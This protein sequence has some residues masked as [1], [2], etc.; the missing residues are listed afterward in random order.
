MNHQPPHPPDDQNPD[1]GISKS[2]RDN[3]SSNNISYRETLKKYGLNPELEQQEEDK[4]KSTINAHVTDI[5]VEPHHDFELEA[6]SSEPIELTRPSDEYHTVPKVIS[7]AWERLLAISDNNR[8]TQESQTQPLDKFNLAD[9]PSPPIGHQNSGSWSRLMHTITRET[10]NPALEDSLE[11]SSLLDSTRLQPDNA[12]Q[13]ALAPSS[14]P[15]PKQ[16]QQP[17][18]TALPP[19]K[20]FGKTLD[21]HKEQSAPPS[22]YSQKLINSKSQEQSDALPSEEAP[23]LLSEQATQKLTSPSQEENQEV[24]S[25]KNTTQ[26]PAAEDNKVTETIQRQDSETPQAEPTN[27]FEDELDKVLEPVDTTF[28]ENFADYTYDVESLSHQ[29][30]IQPPQFSQRLAANSQE[31]YKEVTLPSNTVNSPEINTEQFRHIRSLLFSSEIEQL[32]YLQKRVTEPP[33][34]KALA[35]VLPDAVQLRMHQDE[36]FQEVLKPT[37]SQVLQDTV[38]QEPES[39][40]E[41]LFPVIGPATKRMIQSSIQALVQRLNQSVNAGLDLPSRFKAWRAGIPYGEYFLL[42]SLV[43]QVEHIFLIHTETGIPLVH[44]THP[45]AVQSQDPDLITSMLTAISDFAKDSFQVEADEE[46]NIQRFQVGDFQIVSLQNGPLTLAMAIVGTPPISLQEEAEKTLSTLRFRHNDDVK[47]FSGDT[48]PFETSQKDVESLLHTE[49][50]EVSSKPSGPLLMLLTASLIAAVGF[51]IWRFIESTQWHNFVE[52]IKLEP[53]Y[54][55]SHTESRFFNYYIHGV[56]DPLAVRPQSLLDQA[57]VPQSRTHL[58]FHEFQSTDPL[59]IKKRII[60]ALQPPPEVSITVSEGL[61]MITGQSDNE[62]RQ[63]A[64]VQAPFIP[65]V[66]RLD[67]SRL[68]DSNPKTRLIR[69][70][71]PPDSVRVELSKSGQVLLKGEATHEWILATKK[72]LSQYPNIESVNT[73]F[74]KDLDLEHFNKLIARLRKEFIYFEQG[75]ATVQPESKPTIDQAARI[76]KQLNQDSKLLNIPYRVT[77]VGQSDGTG[78]A[79]QNNKLSL[80]RAT[81]VQKT[82]LQKGITQPKLEVDALLSNEVNPQLRR[83]LFRVSPKE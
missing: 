30:S 34:P 73:K 20:K 59:I 13:Q 38:E 7:S 64:L 70:I 48:Q 8:Y 69:A 71:S 15:E 12:A 21:D 53:G 78:N 39:F 35:T 29:E 10:Y 44:A 68:E 50:K 9:P 52:T 3:E 54:V 75:T 5:A 66:D 43:Y 41:A 14:K 6:L 55:I 74:L 32:H 22:Y 27:L 37:V 80:E 47:N 25:T 42:N 24:L 60:Q 79:Q 62:W 28:L 72:T 81:N 57:E 82:L 11:T 36:A 83:V 61:V 76:L 51:G 18:T 58:N 67:L 16:A 45:N 56:R 4:E 2:S 33:N 46:D 19:A 40:A 65:G 1:K 26:A 63:K 31:P 17:A 23:P 49:Y 77:I